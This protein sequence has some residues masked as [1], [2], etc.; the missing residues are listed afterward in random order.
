MTGIACL[1]FNSIKLQLNPIGDLLALGCAIVWSFYNIFVCKV[2]KRNV[3]N[4][5]I[6]IKAFFYAVLQTVVLM[7][8]EGYELKMDC[9]LKEVNIVN[10]LFLVVFAS[11]L[12]FFLWNKAIEYIGSVKTN[13]YIYAVPVVTT[14]SAVL[15]ID[16]TITEYTL[17]GMVLA[18]SGLVISQLKIKSVKTNKQP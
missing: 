2:Q 13:V 9:L 18:I 7:M 6:T 11:S 8:I 1:S 4:L 12:S 17:L 16:E 15:I 10:Y 5:V 3:K 14:V